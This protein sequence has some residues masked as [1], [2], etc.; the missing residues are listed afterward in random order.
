MENS[1]LQLAESRFS[2]RKF[3][4]TAIEKDKLDA[5]LHAGYVAPTACNRQ[6]QRIIVIDSDEALNKLRR[7]TGSH[8]GCKTAIII[9]YDRSCCW[10]REYDNKLSGEIDASI[11]ATHMM[12]EA[13]ELGIGSTWVMHFIPQA[14]TEEFELLPDIVPVAILMLGYP[15]ED[16]APSSTHKQYLP[17]DKLIFYN[18]V[19]KYDS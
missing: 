2:V 13:S 6:P 7:C 17:A 14:V 8:F 3:N 11:V 18:S 15:T 12:L 5:I 10:K 1:F 9:C 19:K 4:D 16:A